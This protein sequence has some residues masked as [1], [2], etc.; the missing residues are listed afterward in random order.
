M[1]K[2][3]KNDFEFSLGSLL[4][5]FTV[6]FDRLYYAFNLAAVCVSSDRPAAAQWDTFGNGNKRFRINIIKKNN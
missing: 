2:I 3:K 5:D 6:L 1:A 4:P